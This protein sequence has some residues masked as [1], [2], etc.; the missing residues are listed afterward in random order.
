MQTMID[1]LGS[2]KGKGRVS[3]NGFSKRHFPTAVKTVKEM[4]KEK[5]EGDVAIREF[6]QKLVE[7][8]VPIAISEQLINRLKNMQKKEDFEQILPLVNKLITK[9]PDQLRAYLANVKKAKPG[10]Y[11]AALQQVK[12]LIKLAPGAAVPLVLL[13]QLPGA[14]ADNS[15]SDGSNCP[16]SWSPDPILWSIHMAITSIMFAMICYLYSKSCCAKKNND[17]NKLSKKIEQLDSK[18]T[19]ILNGQRYG[20]AQA[21]EVNQ[22]LQ[23]RY[24]LQNQGQQEQV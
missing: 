23:Y 5:L 16:D 6:K 9:S 13:S 2:R 15:T 1:R 19:Q 21:A 10:L 14:A 17:Y 12:A 11:E 22:E 20:R 18:L 8:N 4:P 24:L 3:L 7:N